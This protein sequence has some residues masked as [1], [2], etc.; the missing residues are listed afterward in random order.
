[1]FILAVV[2]FSRY[3]SNFRTY[4]NLSKSSL[5]QVELSLSQAWTKM[6]VKVGVE[7]DDVTPDGREVKIIFC[8]SLE[9]SGMNTNDVHMWLR[10]RCLWPMTKEGFWC[11][12]RQR[13]LGRRV[14]RL[15]IVNFHSF[16]LIF[17]P[18]AVDPCNGGQGRDD[19]HNGGGRPARDCLCSEVQENCIESF[20]EI[21]IEE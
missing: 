10:W 21:W 15:D 18:F 13:N 20:M 4:I 19:L 1:M 3:L 8:D 12:R 9:W 14:P 2:L 6:I 7:C 16:D 5:D 17:L 11:F